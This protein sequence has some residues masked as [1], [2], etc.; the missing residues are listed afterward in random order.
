MNSVENP[1]TQI[2]QAFGAAPVDSAAIATDL[3]AGPDSADIALAA[4]FSGYVESNDPVL[5]AATSGSFAG[6]NKAQTQLA[7]SVPADAA[8]AVDPSAAVAQSDLIVQNSPTN[9]AALQAL[10]ADGV[11]SDGRITPNS[12]AAF[13]L[14]VNYHAATPAALSAVDLEALQ[15]ATPIN[16]AALFA[17][18]SASDS[19]IS[20]GAISL[21]PAAAAQNHNVSGQFLPASD[22]KFL[23]SETPTLPTGNAQSLSSGTILGTNTPLNPAQIGGAA[24][25]P[26]AAGA[27]TGSVADLS[28]AQPPALAS[29]EAT[30]TPQTLN[31][32]T[33]PEQLSVLGGKSSAFEGGSEPSR[34]NNAAAAGQPAYASQQNINPNLDADGQV[35]AVT[36]KGQISGETTNVAA[37]PSRATQIAQAQA[38][39]QAQIQ[40]PTQIIAPTPQAPNSDVGSAAKRDAKASDSLTGDTSKA[41]A[42]GAPV[43]PPLNATSPANHSG[44]NWISPWSTPERAAGWPDGFATSLVSTGLGGLTGNNG[45]LLSGIGMMGGQPNAAFGA[46]V[47]KQLNLNMTRA[48]KAGEQEFSMRMDPPELGRVSVKLRFGQN[49]LVKSQIMAERPETLE[50]LQ[51]EIRGLERAIEAGGH[52]SEQGGISFSLDSSG[53]ESAGKAFAEALQQDRLKEEIEGQSA[54]QGDGIFTGD[55]TEVEI[56]LDEILAH[57]TPETGLDVRV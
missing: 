24:S 45:G 21:G 47:T 5:G 46:H 20:T 10:L 7:Q 2:M 23:F 41:K 33:T 6:L 54:E 9:A 57:V 40:S 38:Q 49:G 18:Q 39:A 34:A 15:S 52:K 4:R 44:L 32:P 53:Q 55:S 30:V 22:L 11:P 37:A 12:A 19:A 51:R 48:V 16:F 17:G 31:M 26:Q 43:T 14:A 1:L 27:F 13:S 35:L 3:Q 56:D 50:L 28:L 8:I 36:Q 29:T 42:A 25:S